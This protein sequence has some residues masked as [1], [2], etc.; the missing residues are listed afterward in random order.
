MSFADHAEGRPL[1]QT[2]IRVLAQISRRIYV[3]V[4]LFALLDLVALALALALG[5]YIPLQIGG[6]V[7]ANAVDTILE[8]LASSMLAVTTFSLTI[9]TAA[10]ATAASNWTP[11]SHLVL[12]EDT[13]TH[14]VL[15][16]FLGS[17][18][19]ALIAIILRAAELFDDRGIVVLFFVTLLVVAAIVV[20]II[21]WII[22]L[23]GL[24][25]LPATARA[26][27]TEAA[28]AMRRSAENPCHGGHAWRGGDIPRD[29]I[30]LRAKRHGYVQQVFEGALQAWADKREA[31]IRVPVS[32]GQYVHH[33]DALAWISGVE[34]LDETTVLREALPIRDVRSFEQDPIFGVS[35]LAEVATRALSPGV[36]DPGTAID[37]VH[38]LAHVLRRGQEAEPVEDGPK[39]DRLWFR[40]L[41]P[42]EL[43]LSSFDPVS[44]EAGDCVEVQIAVQTALAAVA[45]GAPGPVARAARDSAGRCQARAE[46]L[47]QGDADRALYLS[48]IAGT[49]A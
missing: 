22:H 2:V 13:V 16:T 15:A 24:G 10:F 9:M 14:S 49:D 36:N 29:A 26:L 27:E 20:S 18:L 23:E 30:C 47:L 41:D 11:R 4:I 12:R 31:E 38:R 8:L 6:I 28:D 35:V 37:V 7:G 1:L 34:E 46:R 39:C 45:D 19:F 3:R 33:G 32:V 25:S 48:R 40:P 21:R 42:D 44:R 43:F 5:P 17:Y